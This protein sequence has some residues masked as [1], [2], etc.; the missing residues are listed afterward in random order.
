VLAGTPA[1]GSAGDEGAGTVGENVATA[2]PLVIVASVTVVLDP[3]AAA[4]LAV[5]CSPS[6]VGLGV[7][8]A[9]AGQGADHVLGVSV[10]SM[11]TLSAVA[12]S[13]PAPAPVPS[14]AGLTQNPHA[15][16]VQSEYVAGLCP[17]RP[18]AV[19]SSVGTVPVLRSLTQVATSRPPATTLPG[20]YEECAA[21]DMSTGWLGPTSC[22]QASPAVLPPV[23][24]AV[25]LVVDPAAM[26]GSTVGA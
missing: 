26:G 14:A 22:T 23:S 5:P 11:K 25:T 12:V 8:T 10:N 13:T 17:S 20:Q 6:P 7:H 9:A 1:A 19:T 16:T 18:A 4:T 24:G 15:V 2:G 21:T 3:S